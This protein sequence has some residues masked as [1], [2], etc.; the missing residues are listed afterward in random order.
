MQGSFI[1]DKENDMIVKNG[2]AEM[3]PYNQGAQNDGI[4]GSSGNPASL[5][6]EDDERGTN[7]SNEMVSSED[8][9]QQ[10]NIAAP[11]TLDSLLQFLKTSGSPVSGLLDL[12]SLLLEQKEEKVMLR[13]LVDQMKVDITGLRYFL[14]IEYIHIHVCSSS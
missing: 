3:N 2:T 12:R 8:V 1:T 6:E 4:L 11:D 13:T 7:S 10:S 5:L 9:F 14:F